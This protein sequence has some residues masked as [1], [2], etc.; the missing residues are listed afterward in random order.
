LENSRFVFI[1]KFLGCAYITLEETE[2]QLI[3]MFPNTTLNLKKIKASL[4]L[5]G[6]MILIGDRT[7]T[8]AFFTP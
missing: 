6:N 5:E 7:T 8:V 4:K 1:P 2:A 3:L